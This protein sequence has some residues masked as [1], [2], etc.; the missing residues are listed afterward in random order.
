MA[1]SFKS[2]VQQMVFNLAGNDVAS[3]EIAPDLKDLYERSG[4]LHWLT[5]AL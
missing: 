3:A 1:G 2:S 4:N 5:T